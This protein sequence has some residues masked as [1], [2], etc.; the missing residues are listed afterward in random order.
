MFKG[1]I[2]PAEE[3]VIFIKLKFVTMKEKHIFKRVQKLL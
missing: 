1:N 2:P 3:W